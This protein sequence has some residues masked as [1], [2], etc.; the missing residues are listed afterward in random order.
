MARRRHPTPQQVRRSGELFVAAEL[1]RRGVLPTLNFTNTPRIDVVAASPDGT[2][3]VNI[4]AKTKGR[5]SAMWQWNIDKAK[6][7]Q[8]APEQRRCPVK[9]RTLFLAI[10]ALCVAA[11]PTWAQDYDDPYNDPYL[12]P[13]GYESDSPSVDDARE[14]GR[15]LA[16]EAIGQD[17]YQ[18][19]LESQRG[20]QAGQDSWRNMCNAMGGNPA[21]QANCYRTLG[22]W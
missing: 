6:A 5:G 12:N 20:R 18:R 15:R 2:R 11:T 10:I 14:M 1:N 8:R 3:A 22:G 4:Q 13:F 17:P 21:A 16:E 7:E 9:V 19:Y